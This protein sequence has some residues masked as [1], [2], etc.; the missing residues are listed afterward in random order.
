MTGET[1]RDRVSEPSKLRDRIGEAIAEIDQLRV[2]KLSD[3]D[4]R[5]MAEAIVVKLGLRLET[6]YAWSG[7]RSVATGVRYVTGWYGSE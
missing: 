5:F 1:L 6:T 4:I 2:C 3:A 7:G